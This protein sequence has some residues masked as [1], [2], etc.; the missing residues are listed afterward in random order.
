MTRWL[1]TVVVNKLQ[2]LGLSLA[3]EQVEEVELGPGLAEDGGLDAEGSVGPVELDPGELG[4]LDIP[5]DLSSRV[6]TALG[7]LT[8][9]KP[10][11]STK[12]NAISIAV[13]DAT[14]DE[15]TD[16]VL[17]VAVELKPSSEGCADAPPAV[18][19]LSGHPELGHDLAIGVDGGPEAG[20]EGQV[21]VLAKKTVSGGKGSYTSQ[22]ST[23]SQ[24][25][26]KEKQL[27]KSC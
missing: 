16:T 17:A 10:G 7:V 24:V 11:L 18:P 21:A 2:R 27:E 26:Q 19:D 4:R 22:A 1:K 8:E 3:A 20:T 23:R 5:T 15:T 9:A 25:L 12:T 14:S 6:E 13:V